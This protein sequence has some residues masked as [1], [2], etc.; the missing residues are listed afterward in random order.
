[1]VLT[2]A[3]KDTPDKALSRGLSL[4]GRMFMVQI[5]LSS[6]P[7]TQ[8][9]KRLAFCHYTSQCT[10]N[11]YCNISSQEHPAHLPTCGRT[12]CPSKGTASL[13]TT[14]KCNN[15]NQSY[16]VNS[17]E[18]LLLLL[19]FFIMLMELR[20]YEAALAFRYATHGCM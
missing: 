9:S 18:L 11:Q 8:C 14:A 10:G 16:L 5:Y 7:D 20:G 13:P 12:D 4:F 1:M 6:G 19:L 2:T 15:C 3:G 17:K